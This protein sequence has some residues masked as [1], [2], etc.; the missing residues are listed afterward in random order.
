MVSSLTVG[1]GFV[2]RVCFDYTGC[3]NRMSCGAPAATSS[4][5]FGNVLLAASSKMDARGIGSVIRA[6]LIPSLWTP[7]AAVLR[8]TMGQGFKIAFEVRRLG[9]TVVRA[10][11]ETTTAWATQQESWWST[12]QLL[13]PNT[14]ETLCWWAKTAPARHRSPKRCCTSPAVRPAW[15][16]RT[17]GNPTSTTTMRRSGANSPSA[18]PL[19]PFRT[20][21]TRLTC[22]IRPA[23]PTSSATRWPPCK[24]PRWRCSW[25][26]PWQARRS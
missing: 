9:S 20:R 18:P 6:R 19:P 4:S 5:P 16:R 8:Y 13:L 14:C 17:T 10:L 26:T 15:A 21:T 2:P 1:C 23:T 3:A 25:W 11:A 22:L 12:W 7:K 24:R